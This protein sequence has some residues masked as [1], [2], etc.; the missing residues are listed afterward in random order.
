MMISDN[1]LHRFIDAQE[2]V[3]PRV[4][5]ELRNG[6]KTSHWMWYIFPQIAGLGLS[7][8]A[9]YYSIHSIQEAKDYLSHTLLGKRLLE[10][11]T[12]LLNI[13]GKTANDILGSPDDIKLRS[14]MTLFNFIARDQKVFAGML[15]K[16]FSGKPD[17]KTLTILQRL[18][19]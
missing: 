11:S 14:S 16:Y 8:T 3:Y 2:K 19:P 10:C 5:N 9:K 4:L 18:Q 12:L 15:Q 6:E 7:D 13:N 1:S 17:E